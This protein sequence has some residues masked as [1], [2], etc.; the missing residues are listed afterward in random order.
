MKLFNQSPGGEDNAENDHEPDEVEEAGLLFGALTSMLPFM[1]AVDAS[2]L[3][4][5]VVI[6]MVVMVIVVAM[7]V[8]EGHVAAAVVVITPAALAAHVPVAAIHTYVDASVDL[9]LPVWVTR[10]RD[11]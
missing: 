7:E 10:C 9:T 8:V 2:H 3:E 6:V 4:V 1:D 5:S 11:A